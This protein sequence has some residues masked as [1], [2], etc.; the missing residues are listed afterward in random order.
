[1]MP[2]K[3]GKNNQR[4]IDRTGQVYKT[5]EGYEVEIISIINNTDCTIQFKDEYKAIIKNVWVKNLTKGAVSNPYHPY[6]YGIGYMG[7]GSY[8][9]KTHL[10]SYKVWSNIF[11]RCYDEKYQENHLSYK[12]CSVDSKWWNFQVFAEWFEEGYKESFHLDKDILFKGNKVYSPDTCCFVPQEINN[13]F[14]RKQNSKGGLPLGVRK[15]GIKFIAV[16]SKNNDKVYLGTFDTIEEAF[17]AYKTAKEEYIKEMAD[18]W[19]DRIEENVHQAMYNW[20]IEIV[21]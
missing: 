7:E 21:D 2:Q 3:Q 9:S 14:T 15:S 18:E 17:Q 20:T 11:M 1:M 12:D 5:N 4:F 6:T 19:K 8:N 16:T 10:K 13:L